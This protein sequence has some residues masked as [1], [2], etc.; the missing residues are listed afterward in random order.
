MGCTGNILVQ[1]EPALGDGVSGERPMVSGK[2]RTLVCVGERALESG[3]AE[4]AA[5]STV[6]GSVHTVS[7]HL[8]TQAAQGVTIPVLGSNST[9]ALPVPEQS[10][11]APFCLGRQC[12]LKRT[13]CWGRL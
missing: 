13:S 6:L 12:L 4:P 9:T 7:W 10:C 11:L 2:L 1:R 5:P 3:T 8:L